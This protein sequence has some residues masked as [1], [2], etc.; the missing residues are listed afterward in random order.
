LSKENEVKLYRI[1][2]SDQFS[3]YQIVGKEYWVFGDDLIDTINTYKSGVDCL[4]RWTVGEHKN[5]YRMMLEE[6]EDITGVLRIIELFED[7]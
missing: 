5:L 2:T 3:K 1:T 4:C 7:V 6:S